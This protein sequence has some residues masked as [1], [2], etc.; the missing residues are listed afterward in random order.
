MRLFLENETRTPLAVISDTQT[1]GRGR[2]ERPWLASDHTNL[3]MSIAMSFKQIPQPTT[4]LPLLCGHLVS[5]AIEKEFS[6][7]T[8]DLKWPN[9]LGFFQKSTF[10]KVGGI[11]IEVKK[12][13][14]LVGIGVNLKKNT[15][16]PEALPVEAFS[17][18][19]EAPPFRVM[20]KTL[21]ESIFES[22]MHAIAIWKR[23]P[24]RFSG[25]FL[26]YLNNVRFRSFWGRTVSATWGT[27]QPMGIDQNGALLLNSNH[28]ILT[29]HSG[30]LL[31]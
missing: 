22:F 18:T 12:G 31:L 26:E 20:Q 23:N 11:L 15:A 28:E 6:T 16:F 25:E 2:H 3:L 19:P 21:A 14:V 9:D 10:H 1:A 30:E 13:I 5:A 7:P 24:A 27:G 4:L 17:M 29:I 8:L